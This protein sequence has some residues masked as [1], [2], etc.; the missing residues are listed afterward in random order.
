VEWETKRREEIELATGDTAMSIEHG[1]P[2]NVRDERI[3][4]GYGEAVQNIKKW[5]VTGINPNL[6]RGRWKIIAIE[7]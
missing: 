7:V 2:I 1:D 5:M 4:E 6:D 3:E